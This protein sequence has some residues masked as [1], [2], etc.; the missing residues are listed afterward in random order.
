MVGN[1]E[2]VGVYNINSNVPVGSGVGGATAGPSVVLSWSRIYFIV[3]KSDA[4]T[5]FVWTCSESATPQLS[6][7]R[8]GTSNVLT[9]GM[10]VGYHMSSLQGE[11]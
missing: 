9:W 4:R 10:G 7:L 1:R 8:A 5:G 3:V 11:T 6:V 2:W